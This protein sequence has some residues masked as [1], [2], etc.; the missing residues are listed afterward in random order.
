MVTVPEPD[1]VRSSVWLPAGLNVA[2]SAASVIIVTSIAAA[3]DV[4]EPDQPVKLTDDD[5]NVTTVPVRKYSTVD[6]TYVVP[7]TS[8]EPDPDIVRF[9]VLLPVGVNVAVNAAS[10][11]IVTS[12]V[13]EDDVT[14]PDQPVKF[15]DDAVNVTSVP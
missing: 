15:N 9:R 6:D 12:I 13:A 3:F 11:V 2:V 14:S 4:T 5:V 10:V 8:T 7:F 1:I